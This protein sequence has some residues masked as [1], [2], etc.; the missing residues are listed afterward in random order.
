MNKSKWIGSIALGLA[1][2]MTVPTA[3]FANTRTNGISWSSEATDIINHGRSY[4]GTPYEYGAQY[5]VTRTFDCSSFV[6]WVYRNYVT[7]PRSSSDQ[8]EVGTW[9]SRSN[10]RKGD[11]VFFRSYGSSKYSTKITHVAIYAGDGKILHTY[12][13][14]GVRYSDL[15]SGSWS[16]RY[17]KAKRVLK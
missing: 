1:I 15:N 2:C 4:L 3:A 7:L 5:G 12:G 6:K 8:S 9:V 10:L 14:G 16:E 17:V 11:L 13:S